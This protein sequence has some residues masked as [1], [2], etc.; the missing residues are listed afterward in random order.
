MHAKLTSATM[1]KRP[2]SLNH[3]CK[4]EMEIFA[5]INKRKIKW[6]FLYFYRKYEA[7]KV[8]FS[9]KKL[10]FQEEVIGFLF[11]R[12]FLDTSLKNQNRTMISLSFTTMQKIKILDLSSNRESD[13]QKPTN[14]DS[15]QTR[16]PHWKSLENKTV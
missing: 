1:S 16:K 7:H 9:K 14:L 6:L 13:S 4:M 11:K 10:I 8:V 12:K 5:S 2:I 3:I 15:K